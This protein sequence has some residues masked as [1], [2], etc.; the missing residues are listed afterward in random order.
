MT[1]IANESYEEFAAKLQS[2][3]EEDCG[4]E[5]KERIRN[6][7]ER[8]KVRLRKNY[9]FDKKFKGLWDKIKHKTT[10]NVDFDTEKLIESWSK[11]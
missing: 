2:E 4:V 5:F 8:V 3:M 10:Y 6:K 9:Q 11:P 1:V 7:N